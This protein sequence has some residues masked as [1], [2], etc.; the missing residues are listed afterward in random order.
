MEKKEREEKIVNMLVGI[1]DDLFSN[2]K[3]DP[4]P[5]LDFIE[6][7]LDKAREEGY[8]EGIKQNPTITITPV[9][10]ETVGG[11]DSTTYLTSNK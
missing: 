1:K 2:W 4:K 11:Y 9:G 10:K 5:L 8:Q 6:Q 7:E 3:A